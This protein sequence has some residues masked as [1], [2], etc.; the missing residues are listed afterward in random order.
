[1]TDFMS[2][3]S[4]D[5]R[6]FLPSASVGPAIAKQPAADMSGRPNILYIMTDQ[7]Q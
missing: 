3:N 4:D 1:M 6:S 7:Q 5:R 2:S